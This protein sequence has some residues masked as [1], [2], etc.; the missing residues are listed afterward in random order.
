[1]QYRNPIAP[2]ALLLIAMAPAAEAGSSRLAATGGLLQ[3][4]GSAGGGL[5]PWAV[6]AGVGSRD[7]YGGS[8]FCTRVAPS[9]FRLDSCGIAFGIRDRAELSYARH[10]FDLGSIVP[11]QSIDQDVIGVK[12]RLYGD[13]I[14]D[15]DSWAPQVAAGLQF[16]RNRD[17]TIPDAV[18]ARDDQ[19]VDF[20]LAATKVWL[21]GPFG[22]SLV[23][24]L[25]L[26]ATRANQLGI[27]GFGGD[28]ESGHSLHPELSLG[29]FVTDELIFGFE[30][31]DKPDKLSAFEEEAFADVFAVWVPNKH[32]SLTGAWADLGSI[33]GTE[34]QR[35]WYLSLQGSL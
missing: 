26:R 8:A 24:N 28:R 29:S 32:L 10:S 14:F 30:Y 34:T 7:E 21:A 22:R 16:K 4:E 2:F 18:G 27:L 25:T 17:F 11:G 33:A 9:D 31:R 23:G 15:Q 19:G 5:V 35:G 20:Y 1:M 13:A 6:I 12:V 3:I